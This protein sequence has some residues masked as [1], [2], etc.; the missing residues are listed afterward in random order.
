MKITQRTSACKWTR[1]S[2]LQTFVLFLSAINAPWTSTRALAKTVTVEQ[3]ASYV[4]RI[5][6]DLTLRRVTVLPVSDNVDGIYA[7]PIEAQIT[8]LVRSSHRWDFAESGISTAL[9]GMLELE[10][11]PAKVLQLSQG[12]E[13]D[14]MFVASASRGSQGISLRLDLFSRKDGK[15]LAQELLRDH[16]RFE[17]PELREQVN[18][19]YRRLIGKL[20]YEGLILSRQ[21]NRVTINLG[22]SDGIVKD[23]IVTAIQIISVKRHP[24]FN[25]IVSSEKEILGKIKILKVDETLS[26]GSIISEKEKGAIAKLAKISGLDQVNYAEPDSLEPHA[27]GSDINA[28]PDAPIS[29]GKDP[30]EWLPVSPPSFGQVGVQLGIGNYNSAVN[31]SSG[32]LEAKSDFYPSIGLNAELWLN[33]NWTVR[34]ELAQGV[35]SFAN[36]RSGSSPS[37]LN[38]SMSRYSLE[39]GYNFLLRDDF[40]GPKIQVSGGFATYRMYVDDSQPEA[41]TTT[42]FSGLLL[43][44]G[45]SFPISEEKLWFIGGKLNLFLLPT[46]TESPHTSGSSSNATI[47]SFGVSVERKIAENLRATGGLDFSLYSATFTGS[48]TRPAGDSAT[49]ISQRHTVITG[50]INYMF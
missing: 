32:N 47:N 42:T 23:Q 18:T 40:F 38:S 45:G 20:P 19:L 12:V 6:D 31:L 35:I 9:P 17:I 43:G 28:R 30:K 50:G 13:A 25:F 2:R 15:L 37:T 26:F 49:S 8:N 22:K 44:L 4:S 33:P 21:G 3:S 14:A 41:L 48:G 1:L 46:L 24:K 7:R 36:P 27:N 34:A 10:E 29:F 16:P 11:N 39:V 5:D